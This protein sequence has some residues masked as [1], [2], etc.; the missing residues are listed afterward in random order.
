MPSLFG[1]RGYTVLRRQELLPAVIVD[2]VRRLLA[3]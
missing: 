3:D 2:V 1:P